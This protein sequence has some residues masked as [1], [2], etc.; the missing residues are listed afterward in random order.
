MKV[1][2]IL[3]GIRREVIEPWYFCST[4]ERKDRDVNNENRQLD[5]RYA[6]SR[7]IPFEI[8]KGTLRG[9]LATSLIGA[10]VYNLSNL[11][12]VTCS[13]NANSPSELAQ[14]A[15]FASAVA[16]SFFLNAASGIYEY[17][18]ERR[19]NRLSEFGAELLIESQTI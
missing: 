7:D 1:R 9:T 6:Y 16:S 8:F 3:R 2:K 4:S 13:K 17:F 19:N 12:D 15:L 5:S 18:R 11:L 14:F 10:Y